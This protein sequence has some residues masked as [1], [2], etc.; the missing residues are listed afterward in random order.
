MSFLL[1]I[2][3]EK[4][5]KAALSIRSGASTNHFFLDSRHHPDKMNEA[6]YV[7]LKGFVQE[8]GLF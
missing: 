3:R 1:V 2:Q 4:Y 8:N 6:K 7:L 5:S